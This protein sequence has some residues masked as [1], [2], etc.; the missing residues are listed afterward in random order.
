MEIFVFNVFLGSMFEAWVL[1]SVALGFSFFPPLSLF[2]FFFFL[3]SVSV[4]STGYP[5]TR[6][7]L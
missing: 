7:A 5:G 1:S 3:Y 6:A 2:S 4:R